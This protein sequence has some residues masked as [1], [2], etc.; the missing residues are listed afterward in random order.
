MARRVFLHVGTLKSATTYLQGMCD[1]NGETLVAH[2]LL[3]L[4]ARANFAAINDLFGTARSSDKPL[5][6][7]AELVERVNAH[8]GDA[9]VSNEL[10]STRGPR[11]IRRLVQ[12]LEGEVVVIITA[13]DVG[14]VVVS[15][16][17]ERARNR[18]GE[19]W[20]DFMSALT[21][22]GSVD[23]PDLEWFWRRQDLPAMASRFAD[24]VGIERVRIVTVP[25][26]GVSPALVGRRFLDAVDLGDVPALPGPVGANPS[27]GAYSVELM[28]RVQERLS[29][30]ERDRLRP[31]LKF[32]LTRQVLAARR[33]AEPALGLTPVQAEW[34]EQFASRQIQ[35]LRDL[36]VEVFGDLDDLRPE[37][38][39]GTRGIDP[40][41]ATD[42]DLLDVAID[43][44]IGLVD[45]VDS[46]VSRAEP[47]QHPWRLDLNDP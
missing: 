13:R 8:P 47:A 32:V 14:R 18:V 35:G 27:L 39:S 17:Q 25:G 15:Q 6:T 38:Q 36:G 37:D 16:W 7:W 42:S 28:R 2:G 10:L 41:S 26:S 20:S 21:A 9:L 19:S 30:A 46:L 31:A 3:W 40:A 22:D 45:T 4:G 34:A 23:N 5:L 43:A 24:V 29:D 11:K 12:D 44:L 33:G 1:D